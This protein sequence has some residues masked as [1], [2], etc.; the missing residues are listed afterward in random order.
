[1][2]AVWMPL[3]ASAI[4]V[5]PYEFSGFWPNHYLRKMLTV[6][7]ANRSV[8]WWGLNV[9]KASNSEPGKQEREGV[10]KDYIWQRDRHVR[11]D[12]NVLGTIF[13]RIAFVGGDPKRYARLAADW[14]HYVSQSVHNQQCRH[15]C[16]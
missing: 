13:D 14:K 15:S 2:N 9:A 4:E 16:P 10:G 8:F 3:G 6:T 11:I 7:D 12:T 1:M 5:R